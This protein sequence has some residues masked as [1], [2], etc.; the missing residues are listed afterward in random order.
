MVIGFLGLALLD[1]VSDDMRL[2]GL[3]AVLHFTWITIV[4][5]FYSGQETLHT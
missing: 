3:L 1:M 4:C 5:R 2:S